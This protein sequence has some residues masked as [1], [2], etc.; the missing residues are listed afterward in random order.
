MTDPGERIDLPA[1]Q[2]LYYCDADHSYWRCKP[3]GS[4]GRRLTGVTSVIKPIDF[5]PANLMRWAAKTNGEGIATLT[6]DALCCEDVEEM[7]SALMWLSS[8]ESIWRELESQELT[9]DHIRDAKTTIGSNVHERA[10]LS[11]AEG[12]P[13]PDYSGL[14]DAERPYVDA[15]VDFWLDHD[16]EP[17]YVEQVVAEPD[18]LG[19]AGRLDILGRLTSECDSPA[20]ACHA[21]IGQPG[22]IDAKTSRFIFE[23]PHAQIAGYRH[24]AE[25]CGIAE[26]TWGALL[27]LKPEGTYELIEAQAEAEEF[28]AALTV[29][30]ARAAIKRRVNAAR[31]PK[32]MKAV[33]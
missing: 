23:G 33:A 22:V 27:H 10:M 9:Y 15:F 8:A 25:V 1:G 29:Y 2:S 6:A 18:E 31:K 7:R 24:L 19:V 3:D 17:A 21:Y 30:R 32:Q 14:S 11:L 5:D 26:T 20:C 4:R 28:L 16:P 13:T 12:A